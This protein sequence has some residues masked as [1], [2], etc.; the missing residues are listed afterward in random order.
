[1][2]RRPGQ[3]P[4]PLPER[5][6]PFA[7]PGDPAGDAG[8]GGNLPPFASLGLGPAPYPGFERGWEPSEDELADTADLPDRPPSRLGRGVRFLVPVV[9]GLLFVAG[10]VGLIWFDVIGGSGSDTP[11]APAVAGL[12]GSTETPG[13]ATT[14]VSPRSGTPSVAQ[15][16]TPA[17]TRRTPTV[18]TAQP[19]ATRTPDGTA[20]ATAA[21][22]LLIAVGSGEAAGV[23]AGDLGAQLR[24]ALAGQLPG[25]RIEVVADDRLDEAVIFVG[26][27]S[28]AAGFNA[29]AVAGSPLMLVTSPRLPLTGIGRDQADQLLRGGIAD[30]RDAGAA[31]T[32][33]V[34]VL[35]LRGYVP[36][37]AQ[38][39]ATYRDYERLVAGLVDHP[40]GVALV[41]VDVVDFRVN[42]LAVDGV[43]PLRGEGNFLSYPFGPRI[44]VGIRSQQ[45]AELQP[46]IDAALATVGLPVAA[47][48]VASLGFAGDIVPGRSLYQRVGAP[49]DATHSFAGIAAVLAAYDL[50]VANLEGVLATTT[51]GNATPSAVSPAL[52]EGMKLAGIDAVTLANERAG[53]AGAQAVVDTLTALSA[54]GIAAIGA[55]ANLEQA[56][57]PLIVEVDGVKIALLAV[58]GVAANADGSSPGGDAG[59]AT[60]GSPGINPLVVS[61]LRADIRAALEQADVVI[62]YLHI[63]VEDRQTTPDSAVEVAHAAIDA[64]AALVVA[65]HPRV[66][67]GMEIYKGRPIVYSLGSLV[68]DQ[69]QSVQTRQGLILEVTL[70]GATIVGLRFHGVEIEDFNRPRPMTGAEEAVLLDRVWWLSDL[71]GER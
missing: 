36:E 61:R 60:A 53:A 43:D 69:M 51:D 19:A 2:E 30:W 42:V 37:G 52:T 29:Q 26:A 44:Y 10:A 12:L 66:A 1:V 31:P 4:D 49:G 9:V 64:G 67:G 33:A 11:T 41:P 16:R 21:P 32:L 20:A 24:D 23:N 5:R 18:T 7:P 15:A 3:R 6:D 17:S 40:G 34:E 25:R 62:P 35:A 63:G 71:L 45:A 27:D 39:V 46:A 54:A 56:R 55:G 58:S 70:R 50:T 48:P 8:A 28:P 13:I 38:P 22:A 68:A 59:A 57:A 65:T 14:Q 47:A